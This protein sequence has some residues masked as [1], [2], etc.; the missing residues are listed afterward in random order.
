MG[1]WD[2]IGLLACGYTVCMVLGLY[3]FMAVKRAGGRD[4]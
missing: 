1:I 3:I 4:E 2:T